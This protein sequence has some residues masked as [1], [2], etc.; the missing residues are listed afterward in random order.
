MWELIEH[1]AEPDLSPLLS[2][3]DRHLLPGGLLILS[4]SPNSDVIEGTE[5]HQTIQ[6]RPWWQ[7]FFSAAG[8]T[9]NPAIV[10]WFGDDLVRWEANA[11]NSF[12]FALSRT[13]EVPVLT[14]RTLHL[15]ASLS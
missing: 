6:P 7:A 9:D 13:G 11:P 5:L 1:I 8:W 15:A 3:I 10:A 2:N 12:H 14:K 4:V